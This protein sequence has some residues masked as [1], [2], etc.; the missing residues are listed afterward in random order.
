MRVLFLVLDSQIRFL[1][2]SSKEKQTLENCKQTCAEET[3]KIKTKMQELKTKI[4]NEIDRIEQKLILET[5]SYHS[6]LES[7]FGKW[8]DSLARVRQTQTDL[9]S[10]FSPLNVVNLSSLNR[11]DLSS[12]ATKYLLESIEIQGGEEVGNLEVAKSM[13]K[14]EIDSEISKQICAYFGR[15]ILKIVSKAPIFLGNEDSKTHFDK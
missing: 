10:G 8:K 4:I 15:E 9:E 14:K 3:N 6:L 7:N 1:E 5:E 11:K 2:L 13:N 12:D